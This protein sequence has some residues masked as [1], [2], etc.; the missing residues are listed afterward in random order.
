MSENL[1]PHAEPSKT[2]RQ[3]LAIKFLREKARMAHY[4]GDGI[5]VNHLCAI[6]LK[7][8]VHPINA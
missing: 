5:L 6:A 7:N 3:K 4:D 2:D 1:V 8:L